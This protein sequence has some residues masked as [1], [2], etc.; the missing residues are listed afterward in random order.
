[1]GPNS[2]PPGGELEG[3]LRPHVFCR[4]AVVARRRILVRSGDRSG[5]RSWRH[6]RR[7]RLPERGILQARRSTIPMRAH[8]AIS[9]GRRSTSAAKHRSSTPTS[10][11]LPDRMTDNRLVLWVGKFSIVD[12]FDTNKYANNP[13][14]DFMNWALINA[15]TFD[16]AGDAWGY[17][18]GAA[19]EWYQ[20][21]FA[22]RAGVFDLSATPAGGGNNAA[23]YGLDPTFSQQQYV[24]EIEE[25][26]RIWDQPGKL[27]VTGLPEPRQSR[28]LS[29]TPLRCRSR[30]SRLPA[31]PATPW[32]SLRNTYRDR[33]GVSLNLEQ[34]MT[35]TFGMFRP[36]RLG[37]RQYRAVGLYRHRPHRLGRLLVQRQ[38]VGTVGRHHRRCRH[39]QWSRAEP[40]SLF[41]RRRL[42]HPGRRRCAAE[43]RPRTDRRDLL[44]LSRITDRQRSPSII[45]SSPIRATTPTV[46]R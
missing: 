11:N 39:H 36:C 34:Q 13:K 29:P 3:N 38:N 9:F 14:T 7:R 6:P 16:Y 18:Y 15:G 19:A 22:L 33:T 8:S 46:V 24:A 2:L 25:R 12:V 5:P 44:Q 35:E 40:P 20:G 21:I 4:L 23:A 41:R 17:T 45:S 30:A 26:H 10:I 42:W 31:M 32:R 43:L 27:K 28:R 1:M 37:R